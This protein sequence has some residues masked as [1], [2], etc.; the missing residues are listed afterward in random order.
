MIFKNLILTLVVICFIGFPS[1]IFAKPQKPISDLNQFFELAKKEHSTLSDKVSDSSWYIS[2]AL[3]RQ[4]TSY[5]GEMYEKECHVERTASGKAA[6]VRLQTECGGDSCETK[7][8][9]LIEGRT[10]MEIPSGVDTGGTVVV[11]PSLQYVLFDT[12]EGGP[13]GKGVQWKPYIKRLE[14][15]SGGFGKLDELARCVSPSVSPGAKWI[16][17]RDLEANV[18]L[19]PISGGKLHLFYKRPKNA[20]K[21]YVVPY[22]RIVPYPVQ[23]TSPDRMLVTT[24]TNDESDEKKVLKWNEKSPL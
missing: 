22:G 11:L 18:L 3:C 9:V 7:A 2:E 24:N 13:G 6:I 23:F 5:E 15:Q 10:P 16:V 1:L 20:K 21:A 8:W 19:M 4:I 14:I 17:C 12:V